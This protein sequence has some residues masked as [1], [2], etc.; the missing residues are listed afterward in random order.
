M[1]II[2]GMRRK[3]KVLESLPAAAEQNGC[4]QH[5]GFGSIATNQCESGSFETS[6]AP[7]ASGKIPYQSSACIP[8]I[9][10]IGIGKSFRDVSHHLVRGD[11]KSTHWYGP[12]CRS[13]SYQSPTHPTIRS[14]IRELMARAETSF[15]RDRT[16]LGLHWRSYSDQAFRDRPKRAI[17]IA[18][19][20][21]DKYR[22]GIGDQSLKSLDSKADRC[23]TFGRRFKRRGF[24]L[25]S[26]RLRSRDRV[27]RNLMCLSKAD[28]RPVD[29]P[30]SS[31][32]LS[33]CCVTRLSLPMLKIGAMTLSRALLG[34]AFIFR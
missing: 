6:A 21:M 13:P 23:C 11:A 31:A 4:A 1:T 3:R 2:Q 29:V 26:A 34:K 33:H 24:W 5:C 19:L 20:N 30:R 27:G 16:K 22:P 9:P 17:R 8:S 15:R 18:S 14:Q 12:S 28:Q 7:P 10:N 25:R 32:A